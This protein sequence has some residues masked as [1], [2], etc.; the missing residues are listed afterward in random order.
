MF[1][2]T[3]MFN[4]FYNVDGIHVVNNPIVVTLDWSRTCALPE[5]D[6]IS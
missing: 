5:E 2:L 4:L 6:V 1:V 3:F